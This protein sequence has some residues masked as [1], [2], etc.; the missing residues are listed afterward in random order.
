MSGATSSHPG[1][2]VISQDLE[3]HWG[4]R[5]HAGRVGAHYDELAASRQVTLDLADR[6]V[7][8]S[9]RATWATVGFLFAATRDE[10]E[11]HAPEVR[12]SYDRAEFDPYGE[13]VGR[14]EDD[15][16]HHLAGSLV[17]ALAA[18]PGQEVGSHTYSHYYC[19]EAGQSDAEFRADLAAAQGIAATHGL[20]LTSLVLPRNQWNPRYADAVRTSGFNC[21]R[22]PQPSWSHRA[23]ASGEQGIANRAGRLVDSYAGRN[24][25]PTVAWGDVL[26]PDG[27]CDVPASAFVR[28]YSPGRRH[29]EGLRLRRLVAGLRDAARRGRIVHLWWHP[30]NFAAYPAESFAFLDRLLDEFDRLAHAEGMRSLAMCDVSDIANGGAGPDGA[31]PVSAGG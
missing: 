19:L 14:D 13:P 3:L 6:F 12:P 31:P 1:A 22:G 28:P 20:T 16:P 24:P 23:R 10:W 18:A 8:R 15:D 9:I 29:L 17:S 21:F 5:D 4:M 30:H 25:P 11:A 7:E 27:L 26:R 2:L